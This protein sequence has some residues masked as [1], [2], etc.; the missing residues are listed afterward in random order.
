V[1]NQPKKR[2]DGEPKPRGG[3]RRKQLCE[4]SLAN[5]KK[6]PKKWQCV[7]QIEIVK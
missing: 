3:A 7:R 5:L 4:A 6:W 2:D 1:P